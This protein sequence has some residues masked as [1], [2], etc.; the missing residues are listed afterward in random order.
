MANALADQKYL[1]LGLARQGL[2]LARWLTAQGAR[3]T[4]SD[5]KPADQL[6]REIAAL[7]DLPIHYALGGHPIDL[8]DDCDVLCLSGGVPIDLPIV[9]E[10]K[11]RAIPLT[12]DAQREKETLRGIV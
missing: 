4:V 2:A 10:A 9:L 5:M 8:L 6:E 7:R 1:V 12:N 3:V 11:A